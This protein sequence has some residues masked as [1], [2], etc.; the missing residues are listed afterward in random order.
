MLLVDKIV[1]AAKLARGG[2]TGA[3]GAAPA[4]SCCGGMNCRRRL[5]VAGRCGAAA[6]ASTI[7]L[8]G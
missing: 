7:C 1:P 6:S 2:D 8:H 3:C 4:S 5:F